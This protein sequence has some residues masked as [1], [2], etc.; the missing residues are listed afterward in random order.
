M[1]A[2]V[3][4]PTRGDSEPNRFW[5]TTNLGEA[6]PDVMS[7]MCWSI[8]E[9]AEYCWLYAMAAF[10]VIPSVTVPSD[11]NER[12]MSCFYGR[13]A[14]N[15]DAIKKIMAGLPGV[16]PDDFE[17]DLMGSVRPGAPKFRG[18]PARVP[19]M[20]VKTPIALTRTSGRLRRLYDEM[21]AKWS[22]TVFE[23]TRPRPGRPIDR[24]VAAR[25]D[26]RRTFSVHCI[27]RFVFQA[28]QSAVT[29]AAEKAGKSGLAVDLLSGV[30][31]VNE[32]KMADD[33]WRLGRGQIT[34]R[35]FLSSWGYHGP[36]EGN[37]NATV[38]R[39]NPGPIRALAAASA[40]RDQRPADRA[41]LAQAAGAEAERQLLAAVPAIQRPAIRWLLRR[42]RNIIRTLQVGKAAYLIAIDEVR[43][44][45]RE[46]GQQKVS[47]GVLENVDDVFFFTI[48]EC[49]A[50]DAGRIPNVQEIVD[51]RRDTRAAYKAMTLP[52]SFTG[53]P[54]PIEIAADDD[55]TAVELVGAASG[56]GVVEGTARVVLDPSQDVDLDPGDILVCRFTDPS[57]APLMALAD[58]LVID[59]GGS[60]SHGAVVARELGIPYVIGAEGGTRAIRE[61]DQ[62]LVDG[63][64]NVVRVLRRAADVAEEST[65]V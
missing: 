26:F 36:N 11:V 42:M 29:G 8:W 17:R 9:L 18:S 55:A 64:N 13:Q 34:E 35:E 38:W 53:M 54:T 41:A 5:T 58:A 14:L 40:Q 61:G 60:A 12:G 3:T 33:L 51:V 10:G 46:F 32:T 56:G 1:T 31:D 57:W 15:V 43:C 21:Y 25:E 23:Q 2:S 44:T 63:T 7:P 27:W 45:A 59:L 62:V 4:D 19:V 39:E 16:D 49:Q 30:G 65:T 22:T 37:P 24:L 52:L 48:E 50:M 28:G 6:C 47:E 20:L